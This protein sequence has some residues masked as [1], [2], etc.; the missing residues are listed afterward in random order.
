MYPIAEIR[1]VIITNEL[2]NIVTATSTLDEAFS[3]TD[4]ASRR[5]TDGIKNPNP[6]VMRAS[7]FV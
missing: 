3:L 6:K 4:K 2:L 7:R 1:E 5:A